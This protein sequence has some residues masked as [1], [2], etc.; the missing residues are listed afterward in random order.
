MAIGVQ[1]ADVWA[2]AD[3]LLQAGEQPTIERVRLQLGRGSPNTVG[4]HLKAWFRGLSARLNATGQAEAGGPAPDSVTQAAQQFWT[5]ALAAAKAE[6]QQAIAIERQALTNAQEALAA[7]QRALAL[8]Q[9]RLRQRETDLKATIYSLREQAAALR[10]RAE[11]LEKQCQQ[12]DARAT[13]L[14]ARLSEVTER[15]RALQER[16]HEAEQQHRQALAAAEQRHAS[17]ERRWLNDLDVQRQATRKAQDDLEQQRKTAATSQAAHQDVL[18]RAADELRDA[19]DELAH[20]RHESL[21]TKRTIAQLEQAQDALQTQLAMAQ[22]SAAAVHDSLK[23]RIA[24]LNLRLAAQSDQ[25]QV[26]DQQISAQAQV[27]AQ[28]QALAQQV[29]HAASPTPKAKR[30]PQR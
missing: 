19:H 15:E 12:S 2:A 29:R 7:D 13:S 10:D 17:H 28:T 5:L 23:E 21:N 26:K 14:E 22:T 9:E 3:A 24:D 25:L 30:A 6:W 16:Q 18:A 4:P 27:L 20:A 1:E 11:T 8:E